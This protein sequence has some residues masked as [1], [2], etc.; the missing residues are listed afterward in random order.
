[1]DRAIRIIAYL[2]NAGLVILAVLMFAQSHR[3]QE[4]FFAVCAIIPALFNLLAL[5]LGPD[6]E[7]RRLRRKLNKARMRDEL[8]RLEGKKD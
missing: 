3:G 7:E 6:I 5:G 1:M 8:S 4:L 2:C